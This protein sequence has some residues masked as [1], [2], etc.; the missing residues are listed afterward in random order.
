MVLI[1]AQRIAA[2]ACNFSQACVAKP[3]LDGRLAVLCASRD[4]SMQRLRHALLPQHLDVLHGSWKKR[5]VCMMCRLWM[6][7]LRVCMGL[8]PPHLPHKDRLGAIQIRQP[9]L[10]AALLGSGK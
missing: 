7:P 8:S 4:S 9:P 3:V 5:R 6:L 1:G 2:H 10:A